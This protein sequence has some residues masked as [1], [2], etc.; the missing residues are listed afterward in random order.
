MGKYKHTLKSHPTNPAGKLLFP[1]SI[2][3]ISNTWITITD[4]STDIKIFDVDGSFVNSFSTPAPGE[5]PV[6]GVTA[7]AVGI[8][9]SNQDEII[10]GDWDR[11]CI[12]IHA[13]SGVFIKKIP[14]P[15]I[16]FFLATNS[17]LIVISD[18]KAMKVIG[19]TRDGTV[20]FTLD[21]FV[22][23]GE[24][25]GP[26]G[27]TCDSNDDVYIAVTR[28][29]EG[30]VI[31]N[32]GHIHQYDTNGTFTRCIIRDLYCPFGLAMSKD[33]LYITNSTSIV[34]YGQE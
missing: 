29:D 4:Q 27:I 21:K 12:T 9:V 25:G 15:T 1:Y 30:S 28:V 19:M 13:Q 20:M 10:V 22:V 31:A 23:N 8:A 17:H 34:V 24:V 16:P 26:N 32:S 11:K 18:W 3:V 6:P 7:F 2:A 5:K 33:R 14:I